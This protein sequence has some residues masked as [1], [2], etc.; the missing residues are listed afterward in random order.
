[1]FSR[2]RYAS[3][4]TPSGVGEKEMSSGCYKNVG[5]FVQFL[6]K[7]C[8]YVWQVGEFVIFRGTASVFHANHTV[9]A[10]HGAVYWSF[11][12]W[13]VN[14]DNYRVD[15]SILPVALRRPEMLL[16]K[17][18]HPVFPITLL[19]VVKHHFGYVCML[20]S[21]MLQMLMCRLITS[22]FNSEFHPLMRGEPSAHTR[23]DNARP[24]TTPE[25]QQVS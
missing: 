17:K 5:E 11:I 20:W 13:M 14:P 24:L 25:S 21:V 7:V 1:V 12:R 18:I 15:F 9:H 2:L 8:E 3:P 6:L 19:L 16:V 22:L 23:P 10:H 4:K